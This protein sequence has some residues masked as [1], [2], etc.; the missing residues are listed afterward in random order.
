MIKFLLG[1]IGTFNNLLTAIGP[2][3]T[4][5]GRPYDLSLDRAVPHPSPSEEQVPA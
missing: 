5:V 1:E 4:V 2:L 3:S